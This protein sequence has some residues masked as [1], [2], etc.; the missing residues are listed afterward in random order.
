MVRVSFLFKQL[1]PLSP[2]C[3]V[4]KVI[5]ATEISVGICEPQCN[6]AVSC[7]EAFIGNTTSSLGCALEAGTPE[8][9]CNIN[10]LVPGFNYTVMARAC[11]SFNGQN[12]CGQPRGASVRVTGGALKFDI[13]L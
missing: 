12:V 2:R 10:G 5:G 13:L 4:A 7:L 9:S 1:P 3:V 11:V 8:R 6:T